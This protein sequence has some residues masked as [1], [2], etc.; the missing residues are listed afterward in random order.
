M[1]I[2]GVVTAMIS[3]YP[4]NLSF[5]LTT[6]RDE[7]K[8][9]TLTYNEFKTCQGKIQPQLYRSFVRRRDLVMVIIE[10]SLHQSSLVFWLIVPVFIDDTWK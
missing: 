5:C 3:E 6:L 7:K 4:F 10:E 2:E 9:K 8:K 1:K